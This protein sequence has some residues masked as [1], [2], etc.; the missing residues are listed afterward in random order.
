MSLR[1]HQRG[2]RQLGMGAGSHLARPPAVL[3][4]PDIRPRQEM[5]TYLSNRFADD[6]ANSMSAFYSDLDQDI[7][8]GDFVFT[9][10]FVYGAG[11][12]STTPTMD[13]VT[14][15]LVTLAPAAPRRAFAYYNPSAPDLTVDTMG[16]S[17]SWP[18]EVAA[19]CSTVV[20]QRSGLDYW[21]LDWWDDGP[22]TS[23]L[24]AGYDI[25]L[26]ML[27]F[28]WSDTG[29]TVENA[30]LLERSSVLTGIG[31]ME[32]WVIWGDEIASTVDIDVTAIS[33]NLQ[34]VAWVDIFEL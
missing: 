12:S 2:L 11:G 16:L 15:E 14:E 21:T 31:V 28:V 13:N 24:V 10:L 18:S 33:G 3:E 19:A 32:A 22:D 30:T 6:T 9:M 26:A 5:F 8:E 25:H 4:E 29:S 17:W 1:R 20:I 23:V 7:V 34:W 27:V